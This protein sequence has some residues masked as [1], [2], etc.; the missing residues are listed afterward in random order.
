MIYD[1]TP[2]KK[3]RWIENEI[4]KLTKNK[5]TQYYGISYIYGSL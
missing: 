1:I 4:I 5:N 3:C 2:R